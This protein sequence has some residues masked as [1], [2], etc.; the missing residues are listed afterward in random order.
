MQKLTPTRA[1]M[2]VAASSF[3]TVSAWAGAK[4]DLFPWLS[5]PVGEATALALFEAGKLDADGDFLEQVATC[6][7]APSGDRRECIEEAWHERKEELE[8]AEDQ[9]ERR[10]DI[11]EELGSDA[12][13]PEIDPA[14]FSANLTNRY[15]VFTVG[16]TMVYEAMTDEGLERVEITTLPS[17]VEIN[18]VTCRE[19][20]DIAILDGEVIEDT[21]DWF[22]QDQEGNLWYFGEISRNYDEDGFLEDIDGSWR[23]GVD[24]AQPGII[25]KDS[26]VVGE[27]Y[28]QEY[29]INEAEDL[30]RVLA[31]NET[32]TVPAGT[33]TG[34]L[35]TEDGSSLEPDALEYKYYAPGVGLILEIDLESGERLEL[36]QIIP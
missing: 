35:M 21:I 2:F 4:L 31:L 3:L 18:G 23:Y 30:G 19:V 17:T 8:L 27:L 36:V 22:A 14:N 29:L 25:V 1:A 32:V 13:L 10:L 33:F 11:L 20:Q 7:N 24:G 28:R 34:C 9:Y 5:L 15:T 16:R 6:L 26:P 12:Y